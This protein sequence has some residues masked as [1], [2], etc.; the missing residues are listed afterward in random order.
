M[1]ERP[2]IFSGESVQA[3]LDGR[4]TQ[5]RRVIESKLL[6]KQ[7]TLEVYK[8]T[9]HYEAKWISKD[10]TAH[11]CNDLLAHCP[12]GQV[13]DRLWV[14]ETWALRNDG[15]QVMHK[16]GYEEIIKLLDLPDFNIKWR[17][18]IFM[19]RWAS[20]ITLEIAGVRVERVQDITL[21]DVYSEG[22]PLEK[23]TVFV[24]PARGYEIRAEA[25]EW[26]AELWDSLNAKKGYGWEVNLWVWVIEF[27]PLMGNERG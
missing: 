26:F 25:T 1:K 9:D 8:E 5:T 7:G 16:Q 20:R 4:K 22:C 21:S 23:A 6:V 10:A 24:D 13:S 17:P 15:R 14:R 27:I 18:S 12:Y 2:I 11:Y 3:I 19:P